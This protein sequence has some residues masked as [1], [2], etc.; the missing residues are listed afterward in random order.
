MHVST[1][2]NKEEQKREKNKIYI[3]G[4]CM[5]A[6]LAHGFI[7]NTMD[8]EKEEEKEVRCAH[9]GIAHEIV[10]GSE[11]GWTTTNTHQK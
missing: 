7:I 2:E 4:V 5:P 1:R 10:S 6:G 11:M 3:F 9:I 8:E